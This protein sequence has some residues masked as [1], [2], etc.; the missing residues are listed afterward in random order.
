MY[1]YI[2]AT[3]S[4]TMV[5]QI[6][7]SHVS[8][9]VFIVDGHHKLIRWKMVTHAG[10]DGFSR[11]IA[12]MKCSTNNKATTV[13]SLFL[14]AV[15]LYGLPSRVRTD[16]GGENRLVAQHMLENRGTHR[17]SVM[18]GN[19]VH[20]QRIERL[21][22]DMHECVTKLYYRL[23]YFLEEQGLLNPDDDVHLFALHY[24]YIP[25]INQALLCF[26]DGWNNH[27]I[28]TEHNQSPNQLFVAGALRLRQS[29]LTALDFFDRVSDN[30]GVEDDGLPGDDSSDG[31]AIPEVTFALPNEHLQ[32]L[33]Q[34]V[35]PLDNSDNHG[36]E[37]Y[38]RT[39]DSIYNIVSQYPDIYI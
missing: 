3:T 8:H 22:R 10:I 15:S 2:L 4:M 13:Y 1:S 28:R 11:M 25:R 23:F 19:S 12:F 27:G 5:L 32:L 36:I 34:N 17:S 9:N 6:M 33:Q 29:G 35:N 38:E 21:W 31:V 16:Y 18:T 14:N 20:N 30:Y 7:H 37:L 26:K 24:V 39:L